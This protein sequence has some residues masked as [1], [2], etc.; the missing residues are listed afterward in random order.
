MLLLYHILY[1]YH[2]CQ[3]VG[4]DEAIIWYARQNHKN[5]DLNDED[6]SVM[7]FLL[8]FI[9]NWEIFQHVSFLKKGIY[10]L[11]YIFVSFAHLEWQFL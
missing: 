6:Q 11:D 8:G 3:C 2:G 1:F 5:E 7:D 4:V 9:M 10:L